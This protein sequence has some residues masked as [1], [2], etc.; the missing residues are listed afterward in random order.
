VRGYQHEEMVMPGPL[1]AGSFRRASLGTIHMSE[2]SPSRTCPFAV[3]T[4][5]RNYWVHRLF[6][7]LWPPFLFSSRPSTAD[8]KAEPR[9]AAR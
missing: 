8:R 6:C 7:E 1:A 5:P 2:K 3:Q 4:A 9:K